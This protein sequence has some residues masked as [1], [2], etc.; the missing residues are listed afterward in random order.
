MYIVIRI[1][2]ITLFPSYAASILRN[3]FIYV[4]VISI[5]RRGIQNFSFITY[6]SLIIANGQYFW[7]TSFRD[8]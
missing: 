4:C 2:E 3:S 8:I 5:E 1:R 6:M 7:V